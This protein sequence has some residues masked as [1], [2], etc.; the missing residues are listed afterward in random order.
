MERGILAF[1]AALVLADLTLWGVKIL[2]STP[3]FSITFLNHLEI[4]S[5]ET[6]L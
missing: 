5:L 1:D 3:D 2:V 6:A 4:V